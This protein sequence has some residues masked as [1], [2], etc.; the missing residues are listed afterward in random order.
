MIF[1]NAC[2]VS[3]ATSPGIAGIMTGLLPHR[4][5][6]I[7][8]A[9][10]VAE[11][12][13]TLATILKDKDFV[14]AAFVANPVLKPKFGFGNGFDHYRMVN[15]VPPRYKAPANQVNK[16][17]IQWLET[18]TS[19][20]RLFLW[21]HYMEPHGPYHPP[22][23]FLSLFDKD[24][25]SAPDK[26]SLQSKGYNNGKSGIPYYQQQG[27]SPPSRDG[28]DYLARYAAE[29]RFIDSRIGH[30][31]DELRKQNILNN[32]VVV[33]TSDH[34]EALAGDHGYYFSHENGLT[35]DQVHVPLILF[36]PSCDGGTVIDRPVS[37]VGIAPTVLDL[38]GVER[39]E[40][41]DGV[42][43]LDENEDYVV[44][45]R[46]REITVRQGVWKMS[47]DKTEKSIKL[48]NL[49]DD[50]QETTNL[51]EMYPDVVQNL[52]RQIQYLE[53]R[54]ALAEPSRRKKL[55]WKT[56]EALKALGYLTDQ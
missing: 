54:P 49:S 20:N 12:L 7:I 3:N 2:S 15:R 34:G 11:S 37:T 51:K 25:F 39:S 32:S 23:K 24:A 43:L 26:I 45:Q 47:W 44:S 35:Q 31:L 6:V 22:E 30:L 52:E 18:R 42:G 14:T 38:L 10:T 56:K 8:N 9:H 13:P 33:I 16:R 27:F 48:Y 50:P 55:S 4:S 5:G 17:V 28:K 36:Y 19:N 53:S 1:K 21:V 41:F 46:T 40:N 29:V